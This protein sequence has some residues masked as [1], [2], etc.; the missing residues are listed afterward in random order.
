MK[1]VIVEDSRLA[2]QELKELLKAHKE[3]EVVSEAE[4]VAQGIG[5]MRSFEPD[6]L[7]L[8][9]NL[10][11]GNGFDLLDQLTVCPHVI[12]VTAYDQYAI[13]AFERNALDYLLKPV[14]PLRLAQ[15]VGKLP[16]QI[17]NIPIDH[18]VFVKDGE[19]CW[20]IELESVW[21]IESQGNYIQLH[22]ADKK[23]MVYKS[24]SDIEQR[25]PPTQFIRVSR[26][27]IVNINFVKHVELM[28]Q[29][30]LLLTMID[31]SEIEVSRRL[32]SQFKKVFGF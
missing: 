8:D 12:F 18:K 16:K 1:A 30:S 13:Q 27:F 2:R 11:D 3:I 19:R 6:L 32:T 23:P 7:F 20:L 4:N 28:G 5:Q 15:A 25:L 26:Q 29:N 31:D 10:P 14:N 21:Y 22:L 9:I 17:K 24:L